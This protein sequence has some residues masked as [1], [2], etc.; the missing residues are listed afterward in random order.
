LAKEK[1]RGVVQ[2][3]RSAKIALAIIARQAINQSCLDIRGCDSRGRR[4][5][6]DIHGRTPVVPQ[7]KKNQ[8]WLSRTISG[9]SLRNGGWT[10]FDGTLAED[11]SR[12]GSGLSCCRSLVV[13][14]AK[15]MIFLVMQF[16]C[17]TTFLRA[18]SSS[19]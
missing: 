7:N 4:R 3:G 8:Q 2:D 10:G 16:C 1:D 14:L 19:G 12:R 9:P 5:V 13:A 18:R 11:E 6:D 15:V 17:M